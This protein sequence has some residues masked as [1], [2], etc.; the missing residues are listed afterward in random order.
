[1]PPRYYFHIAFIGLF[2][3]IFAL[4]ALA[5][6]PGPVM[7]VDQGQMLQVQDM[8]PMPPPGVLGSVNILPAHS[9]STE[10]LSAYDPES[11]TH[12]P[13]R[14]SPDKSEIIRLDADAGTVIIGNPAHVSILAEN[15]RTLV[16]VP[17][18]PGATYFTV[19]GKNGDIVMQRHV[20]VAGAGEKYVRVRRSCATAENDCQA[21]HVYYCPDTCHEILLNTEA[22]KEDKQ[23]LSKALE[24]QAL[25][26]G[27]K[28]ADS[29]S[30]ASAGQ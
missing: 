20:F 7:E 4:P 11:P 25:A 30:A 21:T 9:L 19:L 22:E 1:M 17:K 16:L 23:D 14:V 24:D 18:A 29:G 27:E 10:E 15:A 3:A 5:Q 6:D 12:P 26:T 28:K 13:V 8:P 2:C